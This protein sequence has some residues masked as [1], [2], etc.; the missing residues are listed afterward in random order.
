[1]FQ[2]VENLYCNP[3][4]LEYYIPKEDW[5][6]SLKVTSSLHHAQTVA[7][8]H[9]VEMKDMEIHLR[10]VLLRGLSEISAVAE[11]RNI[12]YPAIYIYLEPTSKRQKSRVNN[13]YKAF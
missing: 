9:E 7:C 8:V 6:W 5:L 1:M 11:T 10:Y 4:W 13:I 2:Q 3:L 12:T